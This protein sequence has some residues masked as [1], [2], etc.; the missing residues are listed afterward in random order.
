M[1]SDN[2]E[3]LLERCLFEAHGDESIRPEFYR[4][5]LA[6]EVFVVPIGDL[7]VT[8]GAIKAGETIRL[9]IVEKTAYPSRRSILQKTGCAKRI[10]GT[11]RVSDSRPP[12]F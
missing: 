11:R 8:G 4:R 1:T 7:P 2:P 10:P 5:L 9:Q 3:N 6:A 12:I